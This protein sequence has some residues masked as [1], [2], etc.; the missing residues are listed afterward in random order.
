M[1]LVIVVILLISVGIS[2]VLFHFI[3]YLYVCVHR[4]RRSRCRRHH[5]CHL[6]D[7]RKPSSSPLFT[8]VTFSFCI[9]RK[10]GL[11]WWCWRCVFYRRCRLFRAGGGHSHYPPMQYRDVMVVT[12]DTSPLQG[13]VT[14]DAGRM[15]SLA[16]DFVLGLRGAGV[17][18]CVLEGSDRV[19]GSNRAGDINR[20]DDSG[21]DSDNGRVVD[22]AGWETSRVAD[23]A[24][25]RTD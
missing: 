15:T 10:V 8:C 22:R 13:D 4:C 12:S 16:S 20:V 24:V 1:E 6:I 17:P 14:D 21:S 7:G 3:S 9:L 23:V 18:V 2:G 19:G 5:Q 11:E 25:S